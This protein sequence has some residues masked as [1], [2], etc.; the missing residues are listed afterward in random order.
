MQRLRSRS[1]HELRLSNAEL[2]VLGHA[3]LLHDLGKLAVPDSVLLKSDALNDDD[4]ARLR[5]HAGA[6]ARLVGRL[7]YLRRASRRSA[8]TTSATTA[9][10][11][12]TA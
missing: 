1:A 7:A 8:T 6:G 2:D 9:S 12:P 11:I 5:Q 3:A 4:W 10:A